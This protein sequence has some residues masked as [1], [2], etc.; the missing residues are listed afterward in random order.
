M[1]ATKTAILGILSYTKKPLHGYQIKKRLEEWEVAE[2]AEISYGSIYYNLEKMEQEGLIKGKTVKNSKR[3]ERKLYVIT[4][5]GK[6]ELVRLLRKNYSTIERIR[7]PFDIGLSFMPLLQKEEVLKALDKR[8]R[9]CK[10]HIR[11][12]AK[13]REEL[14][15]KIPF[16]AIAIIDH[17]LCHFEAEKRWLENLRKEV[18]KREDYFAD[19]NLGG[20][21][22]NGEHS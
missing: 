19:F 16:F 7:D 18:E 11:C 1:S 4:E 8:I 2:Y 15:G 12:L 14:E 13:E 6:K 5:K 17:A 10:E 3:P 21:N 20:G 22:P 9:F